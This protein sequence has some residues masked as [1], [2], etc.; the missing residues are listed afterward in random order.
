M[1]YE[2]AQA[3]L[4]S[5]TAR[6]FVLDLD[7][8]ILST[9]AGARCA[10]A[11]SL[12]SVVGS[13][14]LTLWDPQQSQ[15]AEAA[16][17]GARAGT[18]SSFEARSAIAGGAA[19]W[20]EVS[21]GP[22]RNET[23]DAEQLLA[24]LRDIS[25]FKAAEAALRAEEE[26]Y[27]LAARATDNAIWDWDLGTGA[28]QW[29]EAMYGLFGYTPAEVGYEV[30]WW[31]AKIHPDDRK[32]VVASLHRAIR[33]K[34]AH[35]SS[36]YRHLRADG[37]YAD[38]LD[39][40]YVIL[41]DEGHAVRMVGAVQ[42]ISTRKAA[43]DELRASELRLRLAL[44]AARMVAWDV[45]L[46]TNFVTRSAN[47]HELLGIGSGPLAEFLDQVHPDDRAKLTAQR[48]GPGENQETVDEFRFIRDD[49]RVVWLEGRSV[50]VADE[51]G[52]PH[53]I[54][55]CFDITDRRANQEKATWAATH[56]PLT[57]LP[58]R[59]LFQARLQEALRVD[60]GAFGI[61]TLD[62]DRFKEIND[63]LGHHAGDALLMEVAS[64]LRDIMGDAV[65]VSRIAGDEFALLSRGS[66]D[67]LSSLS[68][69]V[70]E[71]LRQPVHYDGRSIPCTAS[72]GVACCPE[73]ATDSVEIVK[74]AD[75]ALYA[76]KAQGRDRV[77]VYHPTMREEN[78]KRLTVLSELRQALPEGAIVP[79]YQPKVCLSTGRLTGFEALAR[80]R[81][82][83]R[84]LVP[85]GDFQAAFE[86]HDLA[87]R[88]GRSMVEQVIADIRDWLER[89]LHSC[90]VA[91]NLSAPEFRDPSLADETLEL[92][93]QAG[94]P[95]SS[96]QVE[97]TETVFLGRG[98]D[99]V[100][101]TLRQF[102]HEGI[103]IALDD[104]GTGF[105]SLMHLKH[106]PVS[107]V[108]IDRS[109][110]QGLGREAQDDAIVSAVVGL[111]RSLGLRTI[112]EGVE[113]LEQA[114]HLKEL[115][116]DEGQGFLFAKPMAGSRVPWIIR[117]W[118]EHPRLN[119]PARLTA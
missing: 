115:G 56:D 95:A 112:G 6:L 77:V 9:Q 76:A 106:F 111:G 87:K 63:T 3:L 74:A 29:G 52:R 4:E 91:V 49:G 11:A 78:F 102:H 31:K 54:G 51:R 57:G 13:G 53:I 94:V 86:D 60:E 64:R 62:L 98:A 44:G 93:Q 59:T 65:A 12:S 8:R 90:P 61:L 50:R 100:E 109:F 38:V 81:H 15:A 39:R 89:G 117:K 97:V 88:I 47:S 17:S 10:A 20:F 14:W 80:W 7:G 43:E 37:T 108:K 83:T 101:R 66:A 116:C 82:A 5:S 107:E 16:L 103:R 22:L 99:Q 36:E 58:N 104:F 27:R 96:L 69:Q 68:A 119:E 70:L 73:H 110:V 114:R 21:I 67:V 32:R 2:L 48:D 84:G 41:D 40:G 34:R 45:D 71:A 19:A 25:A 85:P 92:L 118:M 23:G 30:N 75:A 35:W 46:T 26:R 1:R 72:I 113:T 24:V 105:A 42:D 55:V 28:L 79:Y 18:S 33:R